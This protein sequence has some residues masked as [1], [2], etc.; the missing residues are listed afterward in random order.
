MNADVRVGAVALQRVV[1]WCVLEA[2]ARAAQRT[3]QRALQRSGRDPRGAPSLR[4]CRCIALCGQLV[5]GADVQ[6]VYVPNGALT[7]PWPFT[8]PE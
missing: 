5:A 6:L 3:E 8:L 2:L 4:A 1:F 7:V